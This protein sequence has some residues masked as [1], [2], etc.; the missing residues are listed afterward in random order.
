MAMKKMMLLAGLL[1]LGKYCVAQAGQQRQGNVQKVEALK[2]AYISR[3]LDLSP[4][5]ARR[6]WPV[7]NQYQQDLR[8]L[9]QDKRQHQL[10]RK[11]LQA[12]SNEEATQALNNQLDDQQ[13]ALSLR[14]TY[15]QKFMQV[16]SPQ[17]VMLLYKSERDFNNRL[18]R[19]LGKRREMQMKKRSDSNALP[20]GGK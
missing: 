9:V 7:Y 11:E 18:I 16:L 19:E 1:F 3:Q 6:F 13:K 20:E 10:S 4:D 2:I 17:K 5:E 12:A 15:K 8:K 14:K